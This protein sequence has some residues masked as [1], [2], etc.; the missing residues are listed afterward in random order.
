M[1][2]LVRDLNRAYKARAGAVG[3]WTS[4]PDGFWWIEANDADDNVFAF[5]RRVARTASASVVCVA[6]L[7]PVPREGY[8]LGLP[9]AGR[10]REVVNTDVER[11]RRRGRRATWAA[12]RP[13]A[14]PWHGQPYSAELSCRRWA[15]SG[16]CRR[17]EWGAPG[18]P[19]AAAAAEVFPR[20]RAAGAAE[21]FPG[22]PGGPGRLIP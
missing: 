14:M 17:G 7:S 1:Q 3:A 11:L 19:G 13:S 21:G 9:R 10:W 12:W 16:S 15:R 6:N 18:A 2:S 22:P 8:R 5:A 20:G 4:T